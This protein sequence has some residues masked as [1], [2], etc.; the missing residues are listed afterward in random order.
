MVIVLRVNILV[1]WVQVDA[2]EEISDLQFGLGLKVFVQ[3]GDVHD[4]LIVLGAA[5]G[6]DVVVQL[7]K[8]R[9]VV[10]VANV[11]IP[12]QYHVKLL[13]L[14][15]GLEQY[16]ILLFVAE[17]EVV[18]E[19]LGDFFGCQLLK[20]VNQL[21]DF[22]KAVVVAWL[23]LLKA[24]VQPFLQAGES[25]QHFRQLVNGERF[26]YRE[27]I[28]HVAAV[29][30]PDAQQL[31]V[32]EIVS[33]CQVLLK[34][35]VVQN[36]VKLVLPP[37]RVPEILLAEGAVLLRAGGQVPIE[38]VYLQL[39]KVLFQLPFLLSVQLIN[40]FFLF[41]WLWHEVFEAGPKLLNELALF[42]NTL[43]DEG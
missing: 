9:A 38:V 20:Y 15:P 35:Q 24:P 17:L 14:G 5:E 4:L 10:L 18:I 2:P 33:L 3:R 19:E 28:C 42:N 22:Q 7:L 30:R 39:L 37:L 26:N 32:S 13:H 8:M 23:I 12:F 36:M 34:N 40:Q 31:Q 1:F 27:N 16:L 25:G 43:H 11:H 41:L 21:D 29:L 6:T